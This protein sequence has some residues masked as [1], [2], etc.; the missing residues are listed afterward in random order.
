MK[1]MLSLL[2]LAA[3]FPARAQNPADKPKQ[4]NLTEMM[5]AAKRFTQ[6]SAHHKQL[7]RFLGTWTT[8]MRITMGGGEGK[9]S[10]GELRCRWLMTGRW[11]EC[12][13]TGTMLGMPSEFFSV[14]G[15][16][17]FKMSYRVMMVSSIDTAMSTA[18][19]D[20]TPDGKALITYGTVDEYLTGEHDKMAKY[21]WRFDSPDVIRMEVHDLPIGEKNTQVVSIKY[22]RKAEVR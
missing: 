22:T 11:V 17:N 12:R 13:G 18:E 7:E 4:V 6:P 8:E 19:G 5:A 2:L 1:C 10:M 14:M 16:D 15:Y 21:V 20:M 3:V 9:P